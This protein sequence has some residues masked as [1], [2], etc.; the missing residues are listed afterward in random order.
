MSLSHIHPLLYIFPC[1]RLPLHAL[2]SITIYVRWVI[3]HRAFQLLASAGDQQLHT[4]TESNSCGEAVQVMALG[5]NTKG[6]MVFVS[7]SGIA[8]CNVSLSVS[9]PNST[10]TAATSTAGDVQ[11]AAVYQ[12]YALLHRIDS[13]HGNPHG[14]WRA[15]GSPPF[16]KPAQLADLKE[17]S[18]LRPALVPISVVDGTVLFS[19]DIPTQGLFVLVL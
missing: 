13:G 17:A 12:Q 3:C 7:N 19:T 8:S 5:N 15:Q 4:V 1:L 14:V 2:G 10:N 18:A 11:R 9:L 6:A 16:P